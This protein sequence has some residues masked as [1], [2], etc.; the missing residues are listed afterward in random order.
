M[1]ITGSMYT[2]IAGMQ[3]ASQGM[4][5]VSN[6][7]SNVN[8]VGYKGSKVTFEDTFYTAVNSSAGVAQVGTGVTVSNIYGDFSQGSYEDSTS[9]TDL[10]IG[11]NGYFQLVNPENGNT[12]YTRAGD[13]SFD[14]EG[15]LVNSAGYRVQGWQTETDD[16]GSVNAV[17]SITDIQINSYQS[18]PAATTLVTLGLNLDSDGD[19]NCTSATGNAFFSLLESWDATQDTALGDSLYEYQGTITV[20]DE[21][22]SSHDLTVYF[23]QVENADGDNIWEYIVTCD[24]SEDG[25][26]I[27]GQDLSD[28]SAAGL[29]MAG[30][31]TFNSAGELSSM[32]AY[33]LKST[34]SGD[35][36]DLSNWTL[37]DVNEDGEPIF[38]ANFTGVDD[39]NGTDSSSA[40]SVAISFGLSAGDVSGTGW[41]S[42]AEAASNAS[43]IGSNAG[44]LGSLAEAELDSTYTTSYDNSSSTLSASQDGYASGFLQDLSVNSDGVIQ[45]T[46]SNGQIEDLYVLVLA[47]FA[48]E[49]GLQREGGSLFSQTRDSGEALTGRANTGSLG[50][51]SANSLEQSNV[52]MATELVRMI[53]YQRAYDASSKIISTADT[54]M[55]TIISTKR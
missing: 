9:A 6:N 26:T 45:A 8:T 19:D 54:M 28:T 33:T 30:T 23:D 3:T 42:T 47:D 32:T 18:P 44:A 40:S 53:T 10:A 21:N 31:M 48:N 29:L 51:I 52:D 34:A 27:D 5:V 41:N 11:G 4:S 49:D 14:N 20:Y 13:F 37:A 15:Y 2:G 16:D 46:Y 25:R 12:Y 7:L 55:S 22:G 1:S 17:G 38:T 35:L 43:M 36:T 39:A 50:T 24:P